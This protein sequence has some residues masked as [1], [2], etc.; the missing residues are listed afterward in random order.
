M[1]IETVR[2][3][4]LMLMVFMQNIHVLNCRSEKLSVFKVSIK[5]NPF[6]IFSIVGAIVLQIIMM[7]V[8][9]LATFYKQ[10]VSR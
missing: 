9:V 5:K 3:Y 6:V 8:P 7:E 10:I 2:G 4:I 1:D